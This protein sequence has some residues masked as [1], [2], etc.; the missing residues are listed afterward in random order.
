MLVYGGKSDQIVFDYAQQENRLL[1]TCDLGF[2]NIMNF[3]PSRSSGLMVIRIP[4][5]ETIETSNHEV[6]KAVNEV[7]ERL[8]QHLAIVEIGKV[9]LRGR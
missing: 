6:L 5:S 8:K 7:G 9:R 2:S 4:D 3:P 1:I